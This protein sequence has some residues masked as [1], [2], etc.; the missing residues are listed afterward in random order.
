MSSISSEI[1]KEDIESYFEAQG[2]DIQ[3]ESVQL[4]KA[5]R[6]AVVVLVGITAKGN[7]V[8]SLVPRLL[9]GGEKEP[10]KHCLHLHLIKPL[11]T[12]WT[13]VACTKLHLSRVHK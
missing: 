1:M 5:E 7:Y 11:K 8:S 4:L 10:G 2:D 6:K 9:G 3:V 12:T 13:L